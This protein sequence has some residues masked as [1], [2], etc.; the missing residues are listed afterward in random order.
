[1]KQLAWHFDLH[2]PGYVRV[3]TEPDVLA[4]ARELKAARVEEIITF[5][6]CHFGYA[7]YPTRVGTPH[8]GMK[9]DA[10]GDLCAA[11]KAEGIRVLA[12]LSFGIDG[13]AVEKHP[14]WAQLHTPERKP[15]TP[16]L[17]QPVCPFT[18]YTKDLMLPQIAEV[19]TRY[20]PG[21]FFFDTMGALGVCFCEDC[22]KA[23]RQAT[24]KEIPT[25][26]GDPLHAVY[27]RFRHD[28]A[29]E[30]LGRVGRFILERLPGARVGFNQVG[31]LPFPEAMPDG[32]TYLT[33]DFSTSGSQCVQASLNASYGSTA[34]LPS[35]IMPTIFNQGWGDWS[36]SSDTHLRQVA[37]AV[38]ARGARLYMGDRL[39][40]R[41]RLDRRTSHALRVL[42]DAHSRMAAHMP[43]AEAALAPDILI[44]H[45]AHT[46]NGP[47]MSLFA[48]NV[49]ERLLPLE[50]AHRL[51]LDAGLNT[52]V[53]AECYLETWLSKAR[54]VVLPEMPALSPTTNHIL[55]EYV[56]RGGKVLVVGR[57]PSVAGAAMD[58]VGVRQEETAWQDH[59]YLPPWD[60]EF[61]TLVRGDFHR[62][63]LEGATAVCLAIPAW[64]ARHGHRYGWGIG[65][66]CGTPSPF[67]A[68]TR[69]TLGR[70]EI[71][72]LAAPICG[73]YARHANWAQVAWW[74]Q[75]IE[76]M[77]LARRAQVHTAAGAVDLVV[78]ESAASTWA[79][80]VNMNGEQIGWNGRPWAR[81]PG[82][83]PAV[84]ATLEL[85]TAGR[86]QGRVFVDGAPAAASSSGG[87]LQIPLDIRAE[88]TVARVDW[89]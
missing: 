80:L 61:E 43:P 52:A 31:S 22:R 40:P 70:G 16:G 47:D 77:G 60:T 49:R 2:T 10:F 28:R 46:I 56:T 81:T 85:A 19:I 53:A 6:K 32:V 86:G 35:D 50:G 23:F 45:S 41:N 33:L 79:V 58:W 68:L 57:V 76:R 26:P 42:A 4:V 89:K 48:I 73:D 78:Y 88:W 83:A 24:G 64:D 17:F 71:W 1:M 59:I 34:T 44:A 14:E 21:G 67:P 8:P 39:D 3:N 72:T 36:L 65:P 29:F 12:Y 69:H 84:K 9:G 7:Y 66:S 75:M 38:W 63:A 54:L 25:E 15:I 74:R 30:L 5:A 51:M 20:R 11:C 82:P 87:Y 27:G 13:Q 18:A 37:A 62:G 55:R